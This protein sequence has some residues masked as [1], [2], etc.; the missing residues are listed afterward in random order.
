MADDKKGLGL[1]GLLTGG[2][3]SGALG[4]GK[5]IIG[6][7]QAAKGRKQLNRLLAQRPQYT[8]PEA[9]TKAL[10]IYQNLAASEMPGQQYYEQRIGQT[11]A[12]AMTAAERG[13]ISSNV[14]QG[15]VE[16][17]QDKELQALQDLA[18]MGAEYKVGAMQN[19]AG[20]QQMYG[21]QQEKQWEINQMQPWDIRAN[22]AGEQRNVGMQNLYGGISDIASTVMNFAGTKYYTDMMNSIYS[23]QSTG[24][25]I[26][27]DPK[28]KE[29]LKQPID[30]NALGR[31]IHGK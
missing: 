12:R 27:D 29:F 8:I 26:F 2:L 18:R 16:S 1:G 11:T 10:G 7:V 22:M 23:Q 24:K 19:L 14:Y 4:L 9:Y 15:A 17:A 30:I 5:A 6:G 3:I 31:I 21:Q 25:N 20:A 13:A 28:F